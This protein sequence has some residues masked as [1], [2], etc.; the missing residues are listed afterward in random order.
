MLLK[1]DG[2]D[3]IGISAKHHEARLTER[4]QAG[5]AVEQV[6]GDSKQSIDG[7]LLDNGGEHGIV[8]LLIDI[9]K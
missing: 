1:G 8:L 5:K 3:S 9:D 6:Q 7:R 4:E 2:E